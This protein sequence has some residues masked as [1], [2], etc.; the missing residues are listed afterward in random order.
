MRPTFR[1]VREQQPFELRAF[2]AQLSK[3]TLDA[4]FRGG[5]LVSVTLSG[6]E[7]Q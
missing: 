2:Q 4:G 5:Q 1:C 7:V 6:W 3:G